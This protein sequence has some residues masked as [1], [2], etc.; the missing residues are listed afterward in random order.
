M[1]HS[2]TRLLRV[3]DQLKIDSTKGGKKKG[4]IPAPRADKFIKFTHE[5]GGVKVGETIGGV[6]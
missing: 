3:S 1:S 4:F 5:V 2:L 6:R